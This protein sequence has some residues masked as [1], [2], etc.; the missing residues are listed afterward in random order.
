MSNISIEEKEQIIPKKI[1][2]T[3]HTKD[4]PPKMK[5]CVDDLKKKHPD[6]KYYL[7]DDDECREFISANFN[8][9]VIYAF[10]ALIPGAF[11]ADLWRYCILYI[12]GGIYLDIKFNATNH[13]LDQFLDKE[14]YVRDL[15]TFGLHGIYNAFMVCKSGNPMLLQAINQIVENVNNKY[16]GKSPLDVTGP[17]ML[18]KYFSNEDVNQMEF[19]LELDNDN[20]CKIMNNGECVLKM[21][22]E[23]FQERN[24]NQKNAYYCHLWKKREIY[25]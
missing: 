18:L 15:P 22:D 14:Y 3:W 4:L 16:Y 2:Q 1:F 19:Y 20:I 23:Y 12:H 8:E 11:K 9:E 21:Y 10:D 5:K 17:E 24:E 6:F 25:A 7:F 13:A